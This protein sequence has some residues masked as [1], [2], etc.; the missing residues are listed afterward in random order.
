MFESIFRVIFII[1]YPDKLMFGK[2]FDDKGKIF[3]NAEL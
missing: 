2:L 3:L 1:D